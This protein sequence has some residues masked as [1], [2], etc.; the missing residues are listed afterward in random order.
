MTI[1]RTTQPM[2]DAVVERPKYLGLIDFHPPKTG[3][4]YWS[5]NCDDVMC[6]ECGKFGYVE[7]DANVCPACGKEDCLIPREDLPYV[8][9]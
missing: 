1:E 9:D 4:K 2:T 8:I 3:F 5:E 7:N 6:S